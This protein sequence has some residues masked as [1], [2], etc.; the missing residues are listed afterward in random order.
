M[1]KI[2][3]I[4]KKLNQEYGSPESRNDPDT[5]YSLIEVILSQNTNDKNRDRAFTSLKEHFLNPKQIMEA[6]EQEIAEKIS[7]AGLQNLKA[8]RIKNSLRKIKEKRGELDLSFLEEMELSEA[9]DWLLDL[10]GVGP[11]SAAVILNFNFDKNAFPVDTHVFRVSKRLGLISENST[12][13]KAHDVLE[14]KTPDDKM[15]EFH[16]NLIKHGREICRAQK[17]RCEVCFLKENCSYYE[18]KYGN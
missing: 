16:L 12:R 6:D 4:I 2:N 3:T 7:M 1:S 9:R 11:K 10:P 14:S 8:E 15:E 17:P 18:G 13:E 5:I